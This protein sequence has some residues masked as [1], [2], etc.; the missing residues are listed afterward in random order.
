M[1]IFSNIIWPNQSSKSCKLA[2][3]MFGHLGLALSNIVAQFFYL[4]FLK[5]PFFKDTSKAESLTTYLLGQ[6]KTQ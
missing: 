3:E 2:I 4:F 1:Y 5:K 6:V